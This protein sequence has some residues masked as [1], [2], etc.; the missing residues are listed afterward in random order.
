MKNRIVSFL[1][2]LVF[3]IPGIAQDSVTALSGSFR[4]PP[5]ELASHVIWGWEGDMDIAAYSTPPTIPTATYAVNYQM[6]RGIN[7]FE[8]MFWLAGSKSENWMSDPRMKALNDY[9]NR[10]T[11]MLGLGRPGARIAVYY[12]TSTFWMGDRS[13][14]D[15][16]VK[17]AQ[18]LLTHQRDFDWVDDNAFAE[19]LTVGTGLSL[20]HAE[21]DLSGLE[22]IV[23]EGES[24]ITNQ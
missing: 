20:R 11:Y 7:F 3:S 2:S 1:I 13:V 19:A 5:Q 12:P 21:L 10:M 22:F 15:D 23:D 14:S 18:L 6:V 16:L 4:N 24:I 8:F 9:T 17:T